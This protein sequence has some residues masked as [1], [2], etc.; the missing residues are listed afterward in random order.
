MQNLFAFLVA[1]AVLAFVSVFLGAKLT[2][3]GLVVIALVSAYLAGMWWACVATKGSQD[4]W[5]KR[6]VMIVCWPVTLFAAL[7]SRPQ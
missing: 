4:T 7:R 3:V 1:F 2:A 5:R 6:A